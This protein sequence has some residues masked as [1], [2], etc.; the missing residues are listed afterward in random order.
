MLPTHGREEFRIIDYALEKLP[1]QAFMQDNTSPS[2]GVYIDRSAKDKE[3]G[4]YGTV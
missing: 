3:G 1:L 2:L 4:K